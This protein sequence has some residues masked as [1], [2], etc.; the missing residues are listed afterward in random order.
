MGT[1]TKSW[2]P[3][4]RSVPRRQQSPSC[5]ALIGTLLLATAAMAAPL[6]TTASTSTPAALPSTIRIVVPFTPGASN[7]LFARA[8]AEPLGALL[9]ST[10]IVENKPGAGGI[11]GSADVARARPDGGTLLLS[12]NS[13]VT[14][15][16]VDTKLPFDPRTSFSPV[17][18]VAQGAML[19][20]VSN[21]SSWHNVADLLSDARAN[22]IDYGSAGMGSIGQMSAELLASMTGA[23]LTH[24]PYKG[25]SN[26]LTDLIP[27]RVPMMITTSASVSGPLKAGQ[28]RPIAVTSPTPSRFFPELPSMAR[29]VPGYAVDVWWG[30]YAP[31]GLPADMLDRLNEA[32]RKVSH[33][34]RLRELFAA[35]AAEPSDM[36]AAQFKA[37]VNREIDQWQA[38][39]KSRNLRLSD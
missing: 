39:A 9:G 14:R 33:S 28:L 38:L 30:I 25:I 6:D 21:A 37:H 32:I 1:W 7:D 35:E 13:F 4:R 36:S 31:A 17:A 20:V 34:P 16:A 18:M 27:G 22:S 23:Q 10:V 29:D 2:K 5:W 19:L 24:V 11:L 3:D 12:S 26:V 15:T 8:L